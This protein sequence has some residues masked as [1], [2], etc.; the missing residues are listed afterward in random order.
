MPVTRRTG[1]SAAARIS[2]KYTDLHEGRKPDRI[3]QE[4]LPE[5]PKYL[6]DLG[7]VPEIMYW[8]KT[9]EKEAHLYRHKFAAGAMPTIAHDDKGKLR[10]V[11]Q[12][13]LT[14]TERGIEDKKMA[15]RTKKSAKRSI[16]KH[17]GARLRRVRNN[18]LNVETFKKVAVSSVAVGAL[19]SATMI[20]LNMAFEKI[21]Q[22]RG[23]T[24]YKRAGAQA[25]VGVLASVGLQSFG[26]ETVAAGIGIGGVAAGI[27]GAYVQYMHP[28]IAAP[29]PAPAGSVYSRTAAPA[30]AAFDPQSN[31][32]YAAR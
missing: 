20:G 7:Q 32:C 10:F 26:L 25:A 19:A 11:D 9:P 28:A 27:N 23:I 1:Q 12:D 30:G 2:R 15:K 4:K 3:F 13:G 6:V 16:Q 29:A 21:S 14:V 24:G 31:A 18:P 5:N 17:A 8:K 22:L